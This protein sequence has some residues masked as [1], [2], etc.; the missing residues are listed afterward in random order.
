MLLKVLEQ[1]RL[2]LLSSSYLHTVIESLDVVK[3]SQGCQSFISEAKTYQRLISEAEEQ[4]LLSYRNTA[5][6]RRTTG[7]TVLTSYTSPV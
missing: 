6:P 4:P 5:R 2:P 7:T 1:I 3:E